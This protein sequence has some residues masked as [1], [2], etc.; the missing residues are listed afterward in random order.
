MT[1][2]K[3]DLKDFKLQ[4]Y[5][6]KDT[7]KTV[8][9][10]KIIVLQ[11]ITPEGM[12]QISFKVD[13]LCDGY[14]RVN[15]CVTEQKDFDN[16]PVMMYTPNK[17]NYI[18]E[19]RIKKG[20]GQQVPFESCQFNMQFLR[21][22][23]LFQW[24]YQ[25]N[26]YPIIF[27]INYQ[28]QGNLFAFMC[29]GQFT[30]DSSNKVNGVHIVKQIV[31]VSPIKS[32]FDFQINKIPFEIKNI[33]GLDLNDS[34]NTATGEAVGAPAAGGVIDDSEGKECLICLSE[35]K[36]TIIMPCGHLCVCSECGKQIKEKNYNCP[37]CRGDIRS[38]IPFN[39]RMARK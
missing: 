7:I 19:M 36:N 2:A 13:A 20:M 34:S 3:K 30:K 33:Y 21:S 17:D 38:L 27:S 5:L 8:S 4:L 10:L 9:Q 35:E 15:T 6:L 29:Y 32:N 37:V 39:L 12:L 18:Q 23:E 14:L 11:R 22:Y 28:R 16:V 31:L 1:Q 26:Y 24:Q 25:M